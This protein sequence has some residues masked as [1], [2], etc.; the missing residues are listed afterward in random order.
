MSGLINGDAREAAQL[1]AHIISS[2][3]AEF[4][5]LRSLWEKAKFRLRPL[6]GHNDIVTCVV[7]VDSL[8]VSGR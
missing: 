7:A 4:L 5:S 8:V 2:T 6:R 1:I 3:E